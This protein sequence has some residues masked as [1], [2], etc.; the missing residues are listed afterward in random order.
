MRDY[1]PFVITGL[2]T[3]SVY[4]LAA[5]GIVVTYTT[6][7]VFNFAHGTIG[8]V[9]AYAF[10]ELREQHG[11]PTWLAFGLAVFA[12]GPL[13]GA[14]IDRVLLRR[15]HGAATAT[16]ITVSLGLL[17]LLQGGALAIYGPATRTI[18]P[19]F[20]QATFRI[21]DVT[22]GYDDVTLMAIAAV[23]ALALF[24]FFRRTHAGL[25]TR[26][27]VDDPELTALVG[28]PPARVTTLSWMLGCTFAS[29]A[30][31]LLAPVLGVDSVGLTLLAIQAFGA[32]AVGRLVSLP[33]AYLG[34]LAIGVAADLSK[35]Y[36]VSHPLLSG[37][38]TSLPFI[39]LFGVLLLSRPGTFAELTKVSQQARQKTQVVA[40]TAFAKR[41]IYALAL[42]ALVVPA[43]TSDPRMLD[44]TV[45]LAF[46]LIFS[47]LSLLVGLSRQVSLCHAVFVVFGATNLSRL[48]EAGVPYLPALVIGALIMV[49]VAALLALP[50]IRLSG[51]FL[52]IATFGFG[53]LAQSLLYLTD[54]SFG[55]EAL[56]SISR[57]DFLV[58]FSDDRAFYYVVLAVV[59]AGVAVVELIRV[60][61]LGRILRALA[62]SP[63]AVQSLGI[64]PTAA[65]V[66]VF[67]VSGFLAA[68]AGGLIASVP[69]SVNPATFDYFQSLLWVTILATT[70]ALTLGGSVLAAVLLRAVPVIFTSVLV[71]EYQPVVFG[72]AAI[73][74]SQA[75]NGIATLFKVPAAA[76][77][78]RSARARLSPS[79]RRAERVA[80]G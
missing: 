72:L 3:G 21:L 50:A 73:L 22:V 69:G 19:I 65:R 17:V 30:G 32:A 48:Q 26:A 23:G 9:A 58:D 68:I 40:S 51:L 49:P 56:R 1:L 77:L 42:G 54:L 15:L 66:I 8:M 57:P 2:A 36:V 39:V 16:Y 34:A 62:D 18:D 52:A 67:C 71:L 5:M 29:L 75:P 27:V 79:R 59:L 31:V 53:V 38:P 25:Q 7:G 28:T 60:T 61:R 41:P 35:K 55:T 43:F 24:V 78:E 4:A 13:I 11:L 6:S 45:A 64:V 12:I 37:L 63:T 44:A 80:V 76:T 33:G 46:V 47:S 14:L 70:G 74:L 20:S 10:F